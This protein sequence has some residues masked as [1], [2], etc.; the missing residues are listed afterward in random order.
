VRRPLREIRVCDLSQNLAGP[1]C[2][3]ILADLGADVVKVE[4]PGG[5]PARAWGPPFWGEDSTLYLS[6]NRGKRSVVFDLKTE[7]GNEALRRLAARSDIF[8]QALR[9]GVADRLGF[10]YDAVKSLRGDV[11][12]VSLSA[13]GPEGPLKDKPGYDPLMQGFSGMMSLTGCPEGPPARVGGSVVDFGTGMWGAISVLSALQARAATGQGAHLDIALLDTAIAWIS[14]HLLGYLSTG[15]VPDRMGSGLSAIA[16]YRAFPTTDG[17]R[18]IAAGNDGIFARMCDALECPELA[19]DP[20]YATNPERVARRDE[21]FELLVAQTRNLSTAALGE[22]L[23]RHD[24]PS[25]PI[26]DV[27]QVAEDPQIEAAGLLAP[28]PASGIAGYRDVPVSF[29][30][31]GERP[32]SERPPPRTGEHTAEVLDEL[33]LSHH[34]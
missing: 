14:Y 25:A 10:G 11:I 19:T 12:Y 3:Q 31:D 17:Y 24:V 23:D 15:D 18:M 9:P 21:L 27:A 4:P 7:E 29:R 32:R 5:D 2:T 1:F 6:A 13:Y 28:L 34:A 8:V 33:G 22:L 20:R 16:P 30:W 26:Q